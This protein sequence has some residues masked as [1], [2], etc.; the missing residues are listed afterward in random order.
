MTARDSLSRR[1]WLKAFGVAAGAG[2]VQ[3]LS[4]ADAPAQTVCS[5][6]PIGGPR[7][8]PSI[9]GP[10]FY[11]VPPGT[12]T[13]NF[14]TGAQTPPPLKELEF[15]FCG[16]PTALSIASIVGE[17]GDRLDF[18][19]STDPIMG[20]LQ[21]METPVK[22]T[23]SNFTITVDNASGVNQAFAVGATFR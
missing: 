3:G 19:P 10:E 18:N 14:N 16:D 5:F 8:L 2:A 23:S 11:W 17:N 12:Q 13:V 4:A 21:S 20:T 1:A 6:G 15:A 7:S 9:A 22:S